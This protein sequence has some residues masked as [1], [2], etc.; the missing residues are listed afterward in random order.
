MLIKIYICPQKWQI[1]FCL[2]VLILI[3]KNMAIGA[4]IGGALG[5]AGQAIGTVANARANKKS[6]EELKSRETRERDWF[7]RVF[8]EDAMQ[9]ADAQ[10]LLSKTA[11]YMRNN[12]RAVSGRNAVMGGSEAALATAKAGNSGVVSDVASGIVQMSDQRRDAALEKHKDAMN[13]F[14]TENAAI[15]AQKAANIANAT[16]GALTAGA[17]IASGIDGKIGDGGGAAKKA[18]KA[19]NG[20]T[21]TDV[22]SPTQVAVT[23]QS[24]GAVTNG[25]DGA[26]TQTY[27][28][29]SQD[30]YELRK[31][32]GSLQK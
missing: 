19:N 3:D 16:A 1:Y 7:N 29:G 24:S 12:N 11:E 9:R 30:P 2:I 15:E 27:I 28:E 17:Q 18:A 5:L 8:N 31:K 10:A 21:Q 20:Q 4:I 25:T 14:A 26:Y 32:F 23:P 13:T 6:R 22:S